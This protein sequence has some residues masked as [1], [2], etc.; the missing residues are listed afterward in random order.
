MSRGAQPGGAWSRRGVV[1]RRARLGSRLFEKPGASGEKLALARAMRAVPTRAE[2]TLWASLRDRRLGGWK[3]RRQQVIA[4]YIVDFYCAQL[5]LAVEVDGPVHDGRRAE[6]RQ[7]DDAMAAL[8]VRGVR[9]RNA[10][11]V[12]RLD[13][14][15]D[16]LRCCCA[17]IAEHLGSVPARS[18]S[19][20]PSPPSPRSGGGKAG[21]GGCEAQ[22][23]FFPLGARRRGAP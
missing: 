3:F 19:R 21:L 22:G 20:A 18:S 2:A 10:D 16:D 8:G 6:D 17:R 9:V 11:V 13:A 1:R 23:G 12:D 5:W 15:L 7:R 14:L 4:G